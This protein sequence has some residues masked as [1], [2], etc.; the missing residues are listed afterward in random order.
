MNGEIKYLSRIIFVLFAFLFTS[1]IKAQ[2]LSLDVN[3]DLVSRYLWRGINVN[4]QPNIQPAITLG[5]SGFN[6]GFWGSYGLTHQ[7]PSDQYYSTSQEIDTWLSYSVPLNNGMNIG[8]VV[9]DYYF[10]N[11]GIRIGNFNNYDNVNGPGAHTIEAGIN[12]TGPETFPLSLS[13]YV[14][15][16]NDKGNNVYLQAD[17]GVDFNE[18]ALSFF[19]GASTGSK[20]NPAYYGT[21]NFNVINIGINASREIKITEDFSL[22]V[23]CSYILNPRAEI[24]YLIFGITF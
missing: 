17:Y 15:V 6:L 10:P 21:E 11:G 9:T 7:N 1:Q 16:Y 8:A 18:F 24:S 14:N 13:G 3:A 5:Y 22:P 19:I 4:D 12:F 20:D 2:D 23:F